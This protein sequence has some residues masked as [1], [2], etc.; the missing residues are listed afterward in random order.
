ATEAFGTKR[1]GA[2]TVNG[3]LLV[4]TALTWF[5][6]VWMISVSFMVPGQASSMPP[7]FWPDRATLANYRELFTHRD[8]AHHFANSLILAIARL[9]GAGEHRI[10]WSLVLPLLRPVLVTL[11]IFAFLGSWNDFLWPLVVL[12]E[13]RKRTRPVALASLSREHAPGPELMMGGAVLTVL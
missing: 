9:E 6:L 4:V 10:F 11:G 2:L 12:T 1:R 7:R 3:V 5:P 8:I 13:G